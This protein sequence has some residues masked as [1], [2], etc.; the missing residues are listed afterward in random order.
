MQSVGEKLRHK[1]RYGGDR[2]MMGCGT[3]MDPGGEMALENAVGEKSDGVTITEGSDCSTVA[4]TLGDLG[5]DGK[6]DLVWRS[7]SS[8]TVSTWNMNGTSI[9]TQNFNYPGVGLTWRIV[10]TGDFSNPPDGRDDFLWRNTSTHE[11]VVWK[12]NATGGY[13]STVFLQGVGAGWTVVWTGDYDNDGDADIVWRN[14]AGTIVIWIMQG[15]NIVSAQATSIGVGTQ[16]T[17]LG[18]GHFNTTGTADLVFRNSSTGQVAVWFMNGSTYL[19][20]AYFNSSTQRDFIWVGDFDNDGDADIMWRDKSNGSVFVWKMNGVATPEDKTIASNVS[21]FKVIQ[22]VGD[23]NNNGYPD[24]VWR[25]LQTAAISAYL[26][27]ANYVI[28]ANNTISTS[29]GLTWRMQPP[30]GS[31]CQ[32]NTVY[33]SSNWQITSPQGP[34][35]YSKGVTYS[36]SFNPSGIPAGATITN[37][38]RKWSMDPTRI[39]TGLQVTLCHPYHPQGCVNI[40]DYPNIDISMSEF[41]N[42]PA[43]Q[44]MTMKFFVPGTG[45]IP[46]GPA[47]ALENK[48]KV[49]YQY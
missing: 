31:Y 28:G 49:T 7:L 2:G 6:A 36:L 20:A 13:D 41:N 3:E 42:L 1:F 22:G 43:T 26:M 23:L 47:V 8:G 9:G 48:L 29:V 46:L 24:I 33:Q 27:N 15:T 19:S 14:S 44:S 25:D 12:L 35:M 39:P 38:I 11:T 18:A 17:L 16:W 4:A 45:A 5:G 32:I 34:I 10:G 21:A 40:R 30:E 37:V